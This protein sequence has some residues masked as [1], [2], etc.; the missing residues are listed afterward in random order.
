LQASHGERLIKTFVPFIVSQ[1]HNIH[2]IAL[3]LTTTQGNNHQKKNKQTN[4][5]EKIK[6]ITAKKI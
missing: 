2:S 5:E 6:K 4:K 3:I 1:A